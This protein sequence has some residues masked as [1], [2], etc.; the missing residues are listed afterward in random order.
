M[1]SAAYSIYSQPP[2]QQLEFYVDSDDVKRFLSLHRFPNAN[3]VYRI[4]RECSRIISRQVCWFIDWIAA[5]LSWLAM[6]RVLNCLALH[7]LCHCEPSAKQ[8]S[9]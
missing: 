2:N 7:L 5:P 6:T 3:P 8:S 1:D 9:Q 4:P